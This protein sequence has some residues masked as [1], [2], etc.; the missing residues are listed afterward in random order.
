[1]ELFITSFNKK[2]MLI[3]ALNNSWN[4]MS[5][6]TYYK[7]HPKTPITFKIGQ[8]INLACIVLQKTAWVAVAAWRG[9][10]PRGSCKRSCSRG[11]ET[12]SQGEGAAGEAGRG[13]KTV[14]RSGGRVPHGTKHWGGSLLWGLLKHGHL[15]HRWPV[16]TAVVSE[17]VLDILRTVQKMITVLI[18]KWNDWT[19]IE[20]NLDGLFWWWKLRLN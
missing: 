17:N 16:I 1:M 11:A 15:P 4:C 9:R 6:S 12:R 10:L 3:A 13:Q 19:K 2:I 7:M 5:W 14:R 20:P 8:C 18:K